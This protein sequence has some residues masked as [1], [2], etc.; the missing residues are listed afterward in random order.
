MLDLIFIHT[1]KYIIKEIKFKRFWGR[2]D[3]IGS[4]ET[5]SERRRLKALF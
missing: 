4:G 3:Y 1:A 2:I 5:I